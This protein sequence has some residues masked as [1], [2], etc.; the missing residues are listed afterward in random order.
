MTPE[1][2][3]SSNPP[4]FKEPGTEGNSP[5]VSEGVQ[6]DSDYVERP[7]EIHLIARLRELQAVFLKKN[8][9]SA[10]DRPGTQM[11]Y[12]MRKFIERMNGL[13]MSTDKLKKY[14]AFHL[15][16]GSTPIP[17][18]PIIAFDTP[19]GDI[20]DFLEHWK[21]YEIGGEYNPY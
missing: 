7:E 15:L 12:L 4:R 14:R 1:T 10:D 6:V 13:D 8:L 2:D 17:G 11:D 3:T 20:T 5:A 18:I 9:R 21:K 19:N 16:V